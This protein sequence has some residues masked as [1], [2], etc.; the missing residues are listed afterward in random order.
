MSPHWLFFLG[1]RR[2]KDLSTQADYNEVLHETK[3]EPK[4]HKPPKGVEGH[5]LSKGDRKKH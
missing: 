4:R 3:K 5:S 1:K 2:P